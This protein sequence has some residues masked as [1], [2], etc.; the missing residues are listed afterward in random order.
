MVT[1]PDWDPQTGFLGA[2]PLKLGILFVVHIMVSQH[3]WVLWNVPRFPNTAHKTGLYCN[4]ASGDRGCFLED[5]ANLGFGLFRH[6][7]DCPTPSILLRND[8]NMQ[9]ASMCT[10]QIIAPSFSLEH[11]RLR[12][13]PGLTYLA[14]IDTPIPHAPRSSPK[15]YSWCLPSFKSV[16]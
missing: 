13:E 15:P 12:R 6:I 10:L 11:W 8:Y 1:E 14:A 9:I 4:G 2:N 16:S 5:R 3:L 7:G